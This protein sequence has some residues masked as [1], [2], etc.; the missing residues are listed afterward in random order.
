[1]QLTLRPATIDDCPALG[2]VIVTASLKTF[3]G[4][5]P[6]EDFDFAWTPEVSAHNWREYFTT[7]APSGEFFVVATV[8]QRVVGY[9]L[10]GRATDRSDYAR[11]VNAL[12]V[13]PSMQGK[14]V[15][16]A[17]LGYVA[18]RL[19]A[20]GTNSLLI[21]CLKENPSCGFYQRMGGVEVYRAPNWMDRYES[22]E[23]FFGWSDLKE[24][25]K[26]G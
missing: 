1:M 25:A 24:L 4:Q 12:Y 23:I 11:A 18:K 9:V 17:L 5:I 16:R 19:L 22:E 7:A 13:L 10:A 21:G 26:A 15:G 20:E 8:D 6:E 14:G 2:L 3:L